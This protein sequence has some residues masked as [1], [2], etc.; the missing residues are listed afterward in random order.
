MRF[1]KATRLHSF[2]KKYTFADM[3]DKIQTLVHNDK[4]ELIT[5][6]SGLGTTGQVIANGY[7]KDWKA[8]SEIKSLT[9]VPFPNIPEFA[10]D[11]ERLSAT[12]NVEWGSPRFHCCIWSTNKTNPSNVPSVGDWILEGKFSL[13]KS[14]GYPY[15]LYYPF[16]LLTNNIARE[17]GEDV[18]FGFSMENVGYGFPITSGSNPDV[19][20]FSGN[21]VQ[22]MVVI[23]P[24]PEPVIVNVTGGSSSPSPTPTPTQAPPVCTITLGSG[25]TTPIA[26]FYGGTITL[27]V[28]GLV[29]NSTFTFNW[30]KGTTVLNTQTLNSS[31]SGTYTGVFNVADFGASPFTGN[32]DYKFKATQNGVSGESSA[33]TVKPFYVELVPTPTTTN[34]STSF[35]CRAWNVPSNS[36]ASYYWQKNSVNIASSNNYTFGAGLDTYA[37]IN[38]MTGQFA[39]SEYGVGSSNVYRFRMQSGSNSSVVVFSPTFTVT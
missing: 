1:E 27:N 18:R 17:F 39:G 13:Y 2:L 36:T 8:Y 11:S 4:T 31:A 5:S 24:E 20:T 37:I 34:P 9:E 19:I 29:A 21:W 14:F 38:F 25:V 3:E 30:M 12:L 16:D 33:I 32:G 35:Q 15:R 22:E 10:T 7:L 23:A 6:F 26:T 28:T